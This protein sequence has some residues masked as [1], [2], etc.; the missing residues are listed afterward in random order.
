MKIYFYMTT[1]LEHGGGFENSF[2]D[3]AN[4]LNQID[5]IEIEIVTM[6]ERFT[7]RLGYLLS[8]YFRTNLNKNPLHRESSEKIRE[9]L[10]G[11]KYTK[12]RSF[13]ELKNKL[14][15]ADV[16]Y[17]KNEMIE[18]SIIKFILKPNKLPPIVLLCGTTLFYPEPKSLEFKL[19]NLLYTGLVYKFLTNFVS[20]FHVKNSS[21]EAILN[22]LHR[23][24]MVIKIYNPFDFDKFRN[25]AIKLNFELNEPSK[26]NIIWTGRLEQQ[27]GIVDLIEI[28]NALNNNHINSIAWNIAGEGNEKSA[29][30]GLC[31]KWKNVHYYGHVNNI[32]IPSMLKGGD[33]FITTSKAESFGNNIVEANALDLPAIAYRIPGPE[34][35]IEQGLNGLMVD[36]QESF[37]AAISSCVEGKQQFSNPAEVVTTKFNKEKIYIETLNAIKSVVTREEYKRA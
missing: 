14:S 36:S 2:I 33:L 5:N 7:K 32:Y 9:R 26:Y 15:E 30:L 31:D 10:N 11:V 23:N 37:I 13:K 20:Q 29:I 8:I 3:I 35:I 28:V 12:A 24:K 22:K 34:E 18:T 1:I 16:I 27:K 21:D 19:H 25:N 17:A 4:G 6:D